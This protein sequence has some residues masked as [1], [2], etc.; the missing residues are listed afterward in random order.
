MR[1][2]DRS[3]RRAP[4]RSLAA[5]AVA[6]LLAACATPQ[7]EA[8]WRDPQLG[9]KALQGRTVL[10]VCRGLDLTLERICEDR[11]AADAQAIGARVVRAE[12][13]RDTPADPN[14]A[15]ELLLKAA[16]SVRADAVLAMTIE[17]ANIAPAPSGGSVG[18]GVGGSS[19]GWGSR[20][21]GGIGISL[22]IGGASG[23]ALAA[24]TSL[25][26]AVSGK[27]V[28]SGRARASGTV[29]E[30]EQV[31]ELSRVTAD[32]LKATGLF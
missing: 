2:D 4:W 27:L 3:C 31:G 5:T 1:T 12:L 10:V 32:A 30:A 13:A 26:D 11:L 28:W 15:T 29:N 14:A 16:R 7:M 25:N 19:G 21:S 20:T 9:A 17:R 18:I 23:P 6:L 24:S 22:P 8:Q